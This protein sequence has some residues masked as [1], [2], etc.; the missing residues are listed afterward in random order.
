VSSGSVAILN[1]TTTCFR[2]PRSEI[3]YLRFILESYDGLAFMRTLDAS[4]GIVEI[5]WS[6]SREKDVRA[7][8]AALA[9]E[10][11]MAE[12]PAPESY[13]PL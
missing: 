5:A 13:S 4:S 2:I 6:P 9:A 12:V 7:L 8:L 11:P 10:L 3:S 1:F